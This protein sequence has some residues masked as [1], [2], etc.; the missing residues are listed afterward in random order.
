MEAY[1]YDAITGRVMTTLSMSEESLAVQEIPEG[2]ILAIG[3][4]IGNDTEYVDLNT[5]EVIVREEAPN[6][7]CEYDWVLKVWVEDLS[8]LTEQINYRRLSL[9]SQSDWT[10][11]VLSYYIGVYLCPGAWRPW[12]LA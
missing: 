2:R 10:D 11:T 9:L 5:G 8:I 7:Y 4:V 1:T 3:K 6:I 12:R